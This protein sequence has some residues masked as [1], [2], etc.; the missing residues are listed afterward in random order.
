MIFF[1][2]LNKHFIQLFSDFYFYFL[3]IYS[4]SFVN[5]IVPKKFY[6]KCFPYCLLLFYYFRNTVTFIII[7]I[8]IIIIVFVVVVIIVIINIIITTTT[9]IMIISCN[10]MNYYFCDKIKKA[11]D[12]IVSYWAI[13]TKFTLAGSKLK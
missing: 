8:I 5:S 13:T 2:N 10:N 7:I 9:I 1:C 4:Y 12:C 3:F 11:Y 6:G